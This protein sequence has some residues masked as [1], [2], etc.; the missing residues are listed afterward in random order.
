MR[1][2][3]N[4]LDAQKYLSDPDPIRRA[5]SQMKTQLAKRFYKDVSIAPMGEGSG[6]HLDG[7]PVRTPG[8][9]LLELPTE[10]AAG[11]VAEEFAAQ[12][13]KIDPSTMPVYRL[14][15]TAID[16]VA[17]DPAAVRDDIAKFASSDL[18]CY[19]ADAPA[20]LV[21]RQAKAWDPV[22]DWAHRALG[23]RLLLAEGVIHVEQPRPALD[24][25]GAHLALR[26]DPLRLA[27]MHLMTTLTGSALLAMA[28]EAGE[29]DADTAWSAAHVDEDWQAE[30]WGQD[31]E[32]MARR[33]HRKRDMM[34][35]AQLIEAL[36]L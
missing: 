20:G 11:L 32:A 9:T 23:A 5:Q 33:A 6:V 17:I 27:A 19:R 10:K 26:Q 21:E 34:A 31:S 30:Q 36:E 4:D 22:L 12:D 28:L 3:L 1:D 15:N 29:I 7:R 13:E 14:V 35:A 24:A 18:L 8:K 16:G 25:V 2:L